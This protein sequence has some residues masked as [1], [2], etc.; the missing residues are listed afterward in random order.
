MSKLDWRLVAFAAA[1]QLCVACVMDAPEDETATDEEGLINGT[2]TT[3]HPEVVQLWVP[4]DATSSV[5]CTATMISP[6]TFLTAAHC[7]DWVPEFTDRAITQANGVV[8]HQRAHVS[9]EN[10]GDVPVVRILAQGGSAVLGGDDL[11]VGK[12]DRDVTAITPA[13]IATAEP[14][15]TNLTVIGYGCTNSTCTLSA[16]TFL[17]YFYSGQ[18]TSNYANGDSGGPTFTGTLTSTGPIVRVTSATNWSG[19]DVGANP[20]IYRAQVLALSNALATAGVVY[21]SQVQSLGWTAAVGNGTQ[22]G[23]TGQSLRLEGLQVWTQNPGE[24]V[25]YTAYVQD[26]GWQPEVCGGK[27]AG[28][29]GQG[30]RMEA[31]KLR[32]IGG[33][34]F[35]EY[36]AY[37]QGIGWQAWHQNNGVAGTTGQSRRIEAI[38]IM[39]N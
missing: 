22:S 3:A 1:T 25:C 39:F 36:R 33:N 27:L 20:I 8:V 6:S 2:P 24:T 30:K 19:N 15:N 9:I 29:V 26:V 4:R 13:T 37:V 7:I 11:A 31:I 35:V 10:V 5:T 18:T 23:T 16:R 17:T 21:R 12:L 28:T 34:G 32:H 14:S 38:E